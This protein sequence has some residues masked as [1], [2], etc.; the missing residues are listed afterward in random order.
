MQHIQSPWSFG[1]F[2][3]IFFPQELNKIEKQSEN[4]GIKV[5]CIARFFCMWK[6]VYAL[7]KYKT[8]G[9]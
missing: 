3:V 1:P 2:Q 5:T 6:E 4:I 8:Q 9:L 7:H